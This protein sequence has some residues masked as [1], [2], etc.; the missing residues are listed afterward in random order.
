MIRNSFNHGWTVGSNTGF[1]HM[2]HGEPPIQ[3][4]PLNTSKLKNNTVATKGRA[5]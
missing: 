2:S 4:E 1:F 5:L 3:M